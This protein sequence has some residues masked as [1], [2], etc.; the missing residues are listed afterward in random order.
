M[1]KKAE[2]KIA[3]V[4]KELSSQLEEQGKELS[5]AKQNIQNLVQQLENINVTHTEKVQQ[6]SA[7][8]EVIVKS[9]VEEV[10]S[11][12]GAMENNTKLL[13]EQ[14]AQLEASEKSLVE[15]VENLR[16]ER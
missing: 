11:Q 13:T 1:K 10:E 14:I 8:H 3:S 7:E 12:K 4:R 6:M 9:K 5:L 15:T 2:A 16:V